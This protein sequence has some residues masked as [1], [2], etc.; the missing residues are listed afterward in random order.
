MNT[1][2]IPGPA[3]EFDRAHTDTAQRGIDE[4]LRFQSVEER[5]AK[6]DV[7][8][9][10]GV[11]RGIAGEMSV[12]LH[13]E[14]DRT[15]RASLTR[16]AVQQIGPLRPGDLILL[17]KDLRPITSSHYNPIQ[18]FCIGNDTCSRMG[19]IKD[20][21]IGEEAERMM[22]QAVKDGPR[23]S[24][25]RSRERNVECQRTCDEGRR[26][27]VEGNNLLE[28]VLPEECRLQD[29][30][31]TF[32]SDLLEAAPVANGNDDKDDDDSLKLTADNTEDQRE[33]GMTLCQE[34]QPATAKPTTTGVSVSDRDQSGPGPAPTSTWHT[35]T[36]PQASMNDDL[37]LAF[38]ESD[39]DG[40]VAGGRD[41]AL[42]VQ[43]PTTAPQTVAAPVTANRGIDQPSNAFPVAQT[44]GYHRI[45][46]PPPCSTEK[47]P[48]MA[49]ARGATDA[50]FNRVNGDDDDDDDLLA[51]L[52]DPF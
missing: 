37:Y 20:E 10:I 46:P 3:G 15:T 34:T 18:L 32:C 12:L 25:S 13:R 23:A 26:D 48:V 52:G 31:S 33:F 5:L 35:H 24:R 44:G 11:M 16:S 43:P 17:E 29:P 19:A 38:T 39:D 49:A 14:G 27:G 1:Y 41:A 21:E 47:M 50:Q 36:R 30:C 7:L 28:V 2:D 42:K 8:Q 22:G 4:A 45:D 9:V 6:G 51:G 40:E